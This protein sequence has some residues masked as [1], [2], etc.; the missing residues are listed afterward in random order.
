MQNQNSPIIY[1]CTPVNFT[2]FKLLEG[3]SSPGKNIFYLQYLR[4]NE[5]GQGVFRCPEDPHHLLN[6]S[7]KEW[8]NNAFFTHT[9]LS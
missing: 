9:I 5:N 7:R 8:D 2:G 1:S 4:T 3:L 6:I